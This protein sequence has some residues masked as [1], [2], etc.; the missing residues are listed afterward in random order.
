MTKI[1]ATIYPNPK[2]R[3]IVMFLCYYLLTQNYFSTYKIISMIFKKKHIT[4]KK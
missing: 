2:V 4:V 1:F 3:F